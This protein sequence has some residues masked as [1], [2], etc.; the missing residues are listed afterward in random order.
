[1][2]NED[3]TGTPPTDD[4]LTCYAINTYGSGMHPYADESSL[5]YFEPA[6]VVD[7]LHDLRDDM[8]EDTSGRID[9]LITHYKD[10]G[11]YAE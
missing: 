1:M 11:G 3:P 4:Q 9:R 5:P 6:Y 7:C 10:L 2:T 8:M